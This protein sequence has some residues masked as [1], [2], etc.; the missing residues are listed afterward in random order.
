MNP[1]QLAE[2][3]EQR[4]FLLRSL[5]DLE[6]E[7]AVGD[8][9][10]VDYHELKEGYTV[11]AAATLRAIDDGRNRLP[12]QPRPNWARR[13][14]VMGG[15]VGAVVV[16]WW[17]LATWSAERTP[18]QEITGLD[19][20]S[21]QQQLMAQARAL[22]FQSPGDAAALY[23]QVLATDPDNVEAL[24]YRGW[25]LAL[26]A[27][28]TGDAASGD[29]SD[30]DDVVAELRDAVD[31]LRKATDLDPTYPD[32]KC[33]LGIVNFRILRQPAA[34]QPWVAACLAANPPADIRDLVQG[35]NEE[36]AA[37]LEAAPPTTA[38]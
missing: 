18:G 11:R 34:A 38:P 1:D 21:A 2:L 36:I 6:R 32:P 4:T 24:T 22:Q 13:L 8:V 19:P 26:D 33:F 15:L 16:I 23:A 7:H 37:A 10:D 35:M 27:V 31:S 3:E 17:A 9:D 12:Q 20:R 28:Q 29:A 5:V 30:G 14:L 25:T